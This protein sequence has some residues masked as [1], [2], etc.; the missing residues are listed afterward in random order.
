LPD[1][2]I[3]AYGLDVETFLQYTIDNGKK[4]WDKIN[5]QSK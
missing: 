1:D 4:S 3:E 5:G 2:L